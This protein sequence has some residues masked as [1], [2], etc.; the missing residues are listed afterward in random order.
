MTGGSRGAEGQKTLTAFV[1]IAL[2]EARKAGIDC[3]GLSHTVRRDATRY[4]KR[5]LSS[6]LQRP[7]TVAICAYALALL[8]NDPSYDPMV[9]LL[10]AATEGSYWTDSESPLFTLEATGYGLLA[11]LKSG[12]LEEAAAP[13][14]WLNSQRRRGGGY[15]S[16]QPTLVVLQALTEYL[17]LKPPGKDVSLQVQL[18][19]PGRIDLT[20]HFDARSAYVPRSTKAPLVF[21][22]E[23]RGNGQGIL[24]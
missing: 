21:A 17:A 9:P 1:L 5:S 13:F 24:E 6:P 8:G 18:K 11:L 20:Y 22:V 15:G 14:N 3:E 12:R 16:T 23:A 4:L 19:L 2:A 10:R 7:Y